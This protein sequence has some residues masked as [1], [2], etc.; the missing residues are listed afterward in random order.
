MP[1]VLALLICSSLVSS[2]HVGQWG[3]A[4]GPWQ[5]ARLHTL[6]GFMNYGGQLRGSGLHTSADSAICAAVLPNLPLQAKLALPTVTQ[7]APPS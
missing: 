2:K 1:G 7:S 6:V 3:T 5:A 4:T